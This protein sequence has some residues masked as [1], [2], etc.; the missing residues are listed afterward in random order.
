MQE[1]FVQLIVIFLKSCQHFQ[2]L[3]WPCQA[4]LLFDFDVDVVV[5]VNVDVNVAVDD[6]VD[7]AV[8]W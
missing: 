5:D 2:A 7:I 3:T 1:F 8:D 4:R 6:D